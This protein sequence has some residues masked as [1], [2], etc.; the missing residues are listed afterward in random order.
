LGRL[1]LALIGMLL[2]TPVVLKVF[3]P[4][5]IDCERGSF[6][7]TVIYASVGFLCLSLIEWLI[8][9]WWDAFLGWRR[10]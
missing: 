8:G 7:L 3:E 2:L 9:G 1:V 5:C 4:I 6:E 10:Q